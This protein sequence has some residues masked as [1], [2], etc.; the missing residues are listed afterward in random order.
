MKVVFPYS[1]LVCVSDSF[2]LFLDCI[3]VR[4]PLDLFLCGAVV[5][6]SITSH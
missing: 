4:V 2:E 5:G 1:G 6:F 3:N